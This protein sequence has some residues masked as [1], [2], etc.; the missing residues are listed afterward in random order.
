MSSFGSDQILVFD[1]NTGRNI[2][3][4]MVLLC[5]RVYRALTP[6]FNILTII[7]SKV[8]T[9]RLLAILRLLIAQKV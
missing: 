4:F 1:V 8:I 9:L 3:H 5:I 2:M 6:Q 7:H